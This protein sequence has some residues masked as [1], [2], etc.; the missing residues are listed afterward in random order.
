[1]RQRV[2]DTNSAHSLQ[3]LF[4]EDSFVLFLL[5]NISSLLSGLILLFVSSA[6]CYPTP[7]E[8]PGRSSRQRAAK[9]FPKGTTAASLLARAE[10]ETSLNTVSET[11]FARTAMCWVG[12]TG[13][14]NEAC[15]V[16]LFFSVQ[17]V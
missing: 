12:L 3:L 14:T 1:M 7:G 17:G 16:G 11:K 6:V 2:P 10:N 4:S 8:A 13:V 15:P 9:S 5:L